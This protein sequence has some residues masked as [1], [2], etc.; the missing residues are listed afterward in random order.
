MPWA[1][2]AVSKF[3]RNRKTRYNYHMTAELKNKDDQT[4]DYIAELE[5]TEARRRDFKQ[6]GNATSLK[7]FQDWVEA[8]K[9]DEEAE[10]PATTPSK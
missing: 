2:S 10:W 3:A 4:A 5:F 8:R 1:L 9:S 7:A 6:H